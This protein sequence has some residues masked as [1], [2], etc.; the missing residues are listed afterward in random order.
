MFRQNA[1][2]PRG[3][4]P[5]QMEMQY[6]L[7][8]YQFIKHAY[9]LEFI[10]PTQKGTKLRLYFDEFPETGEKEESFKCTAIFFGKPRQISNSRPVQ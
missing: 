6:C 8:Y 10:A 7:L 9:G 4:T 1:F 2:K 3:L 5:K